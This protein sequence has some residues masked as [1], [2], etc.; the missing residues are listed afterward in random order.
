MRLKRYI[1]EYDIPLL[2]EKINKKEITSMLNSNDVLIGAEF[3]FIVDDAGISD[4]L[5]RMYDNAVND[6]ENYNDNVENYREEYEEINDKRDKLEDDVTKLEDEIDRLST[7][8][9]DEDEEL[10]DNLETEK[11][12]KETELKETETE[13][14]ELYPPSIGSDYE[15]YMHQ[16]GWDSYVDPGQEVDEPPHP[17][18]AN[19]TSEMEPEQIEQWIDNVNPRPPFTDWE[20]GEYGYS[21][22]RP[23][24]TTWGVEPDSSLNTGGIEIKSPPLPL[25]EFKNICKQMF[26]WIKVV[27]TTDSS[28]GFH[29]HMSLKNVKDLKSELDLM[30]LVLFTD[31]QYIFQHFKERKNNTYTQSMKEKIK[32]GTLELSDWSAFIDTKKLKRIATS[33]HYSGISLDGLSDNKQHIEYRYLGGTDYHRK[34]NK[35]QV[36]IAQY[37]YNLNLACNTSFKHKE[38]ILKTQRL[39][40]KVESNIM[41]EIYRVID[42]MIILNDKLIEDNKGSE[43][44]G[45]WLRK[46]RKTVNISVI[47]K[48]WT[49]WSNFV[50]H[51]IMGK[52]LKIMGWKDFGMEIDDYSLM[53]DRW[54]K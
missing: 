36:I 51:D 47:N 40:R 50:L 30:K 35:V 43:K 1:N 6:L 26:D 8:D 2:L 3:E 5:Q 39:F 34:W 44:A 45:K 10:L 20:V 28:C 27:G 29:I 46:L 38:Y 37:A 33:D 32:G 14:E 21:S 4:E 54:T 48:K 16:I 19:D 23:G 25:K 13:L 7:L 53:N 49:N 11:E 41:S 15:D 18:D 31:E 22:P 42:N 12:E 24:D 17:E 52:W 9:Y